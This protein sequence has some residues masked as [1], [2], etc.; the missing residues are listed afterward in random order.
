MKQCFFAVA[1]VIISSALHAQQSPDDSTVHALDE[2]I[3]TANRYPQKKQETGKV[4]TVIGRE[5]LMHSQ[6]KSLAEILNTVAG[7]TILGVNNSPGTNL[8][9]SIRGASAGN[10]LILIDGIPVTDPSV[11]NNYFDL[12]LL[13]TDQ[14]ERI[15][16]LKG[17][18]STLYGSDAVAGV[19][20]IITKKNSG[21]RFGINA[22]VSAG[23]YN[24]FQESAGIDGNTKKLRYALGYSR[25]TSDGFSA[26]TD[27]TGSGSFDKD[28]IYQQAL[29]GNFS[30]RLSPRLDLR[31]FSQYNYYR[32]G[33]DAAAFTDDKD[34]AVKNRN[35]QSG[36]GLTY[37]YGQNT[38]HV[39]YLFNYVSRDYLDDS[40]DFSNPYAVFSSSSY[41]GRTQFAEIYTNWKKNRWEL[42]TGTDFR[43]NNTFQQYFSTGAYGPYEPPVLNAHMSQISPYASFV[44]HGPAGITVEAGSRWNH[45][46]VYGNNVTYTFNPSVLLKKL[47]LFLNIYSA[48]KTPTL[49]QLYDPSSG[50]TA[51]RPEESKI[52]ELGFDVFH[53]AAWHFRAVGFYRN[54]RN[55]IQYIITNP[56]TYEARYRNISNQKNYGTELEAS[57]KA[58]QWTVSANYTY[59]DGQTRSGYDG[60]GLPLG[61]DTTYFNLYRIPRHALNLSAGWQVSRQIFISTLMHTVS[62]RK[63]FI[64]GSA[65]QTLR[66]YCTIDV[67][68]EYQWK[69]RWKIFV[70]LKN[71]TASRYVDFLGYNTRRF[72]C[73]LGVQL[74][75]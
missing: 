56:A 57:Y 8:T 44:Y 30:F 48:Y 28:G 23:S 15:E 26:A 19:I 71:I 20:N 18:Q 36:T 29:T 73:M 34:Y 67:Y 52:G 65:P 69:L 63:E 53:T 46:S 12:N 22:K 43:Y 45:H 9:A 51:L 41:I 49:Y 4:L 39:N 47:K 5:Q 64:Y 14:V 16:I 24:T 27:S 60:T 13:S 62:K 38:L 66:G 70:S 6:G 75:M 1:A 21:K 11:N 2:V 17:G 55:T 42:T 50:N 37:R 58:K 61:K 40:T 35:L 72:N 54:S 7:T 31:I 25:S 74:T 32:A 59:T 33:L 68:S 10:T 3:I